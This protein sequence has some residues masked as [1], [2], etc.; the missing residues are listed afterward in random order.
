MTLLSIER[1]LMS[2]RILI[3]V[4]AC[5]LGGLIAPS[6]HASVDSSAT[7]SYPAR[8]GKVQ[9][10]P[11]IDAKVVSYLRYEAAGGRLMKYRIIGQR[12]DSL[13]RQWT[14]VRLSVRPGSGW[15]LAKNLRDDPAR[16]F[17]RRDPPLGPCINGW[18]QMPVSGIDH[19]TWSFRGQRAPNPGRYRWGTCHTVR[20]TM[21]II[22]RY[23]RAHPSAPRVAVGD[24]SF[25]GGG[26]I[27]GHASHE[28]GVDVDIYYPRRDGRE[29][30]PKSV[31]QV[32]RRL[33]QDLI[34]RSV[35]A[36]ATDVFVGTGMGFF[37]TRRGVVQAIPHHQDH[38]HIRFAR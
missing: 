34:S 6:A 32:N 23:R 11:R 7:A 38:A 4:L 10:A 36:G 16:R 37:G 33:S 9:A 31:S 17:V 27:D 26:P 20:T 13:G 21:K 2:R 1:G 22:H 28:L 18:M 30:E 25:R 24:L 19:F 5:L 29:R 35:R 3:L 12:I 15:T 8:A 14:R